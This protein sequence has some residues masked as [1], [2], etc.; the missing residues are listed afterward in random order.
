[1][2]SAVGKFQLNA[3]LILMLEL[4]IPGTRMWRRGAN[5]EGDTANFV[6]SEQI[7][8][9][10]GFKFS[11]LQVY[12]PLLFFFSQFKGSLLFLV[13]CN[14]LAFPLLGSRFNSTSLGANR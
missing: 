13:D 7:M 4:P 5:L 3:C 14:R 12:I 8:E 10:N 2:T 11:L 6:E 9:I 1:M